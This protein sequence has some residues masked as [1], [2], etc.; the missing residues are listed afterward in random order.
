MASRRTLSARRLHRDRRPAENVVAFYN[1]RRTYEQWIKEGRGAIKRTRLSCRF[2]A[3]NAFASNLGKFLRTLTK[4][5]P[6]KD[7]SLTMLKEKVDQDRREGRRPRALCR[8]PD[9]RGR[10]FEEPVRRESTNDR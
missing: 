1:K 10:H 5:E 3:A 7:W 8:F 6:I 4:P 2:F 9:R